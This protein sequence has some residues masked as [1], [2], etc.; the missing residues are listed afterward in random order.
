MSTAVPELIGLELVS[1]LEAI[2]TAN[3]YAF[4][5][6]GVSR[7]NRRANDQ[8]F[9]NLEIIVE[10]GED[11]YNEALTHAGNPAAI[12]YDLAFTILGFV[13]NS[14][15]STTPDATSENAML[16][17]IKKAVAGT[18]TW[19]TFDGNA[20]IADWGQS[21]PINDEEGAYSGVSVPLIVTYRV[22]ETDPFVARA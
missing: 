20:V 10:Q 1:R 9:R 2:T 19:H 11:V 7:M 13:R 5:A 8:R 22:S 12:A 18:A 17:A 21:E 16:A 14:D 4:D 15:A 3:G 6:A